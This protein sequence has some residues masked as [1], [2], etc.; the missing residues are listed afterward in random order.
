MIGKIAARCG[1][2]S[3]IPGCPLCHFPHD[4]CLI[5]ASHNHQSEIR[6]EVISLGG[7]WGKKV[8]SYLPELCQDCIRTGNERLN[9]PKIRVHTLLQISPEVFLFQSARSTASPNFRVPADPPRSRVR[10]PCAST[11]CTAT[12]MRSEPVWSPQ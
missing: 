5:S 6:H 2:L 4:V 3:G 10:I 7:D 8:Q 9:I 12:S 1:T 11:S